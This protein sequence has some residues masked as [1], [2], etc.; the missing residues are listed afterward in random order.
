MARQEANNTFQ[1]GMIKDLN[2]INT[3]N[4]TLTDCLNGTLITYNG[5]EFVLQNDLGNFELENCKLP[6]NFIPVG[7]KSY[8]DILYIVSYNPI[9][10]ETEIGS[11]PAP[12]E[13]FDSS[14]NS[15]EIKPVSYFTDKDGDAKPNDKLYPGKLYSKL[16]NRPLSLF[17]GGEDIENYKLNP[18]DQYILNT[19]D[20]EQPDF[21]YQTLDWYILDD[22]RKT[23]D[24]DD[25]LI[26]ENSQDD[27]TI[28]WDIP[29]W[30]A[31]KYK[32]C[33]PDRFNVNVRTLDIPEFAILNKQQ[34]VTLKLSTQLLISDL[35]FQ[36]I[37]NQN[38]NENVFKHLKIRVI[39][40]INTGVTVKVK[41]NET[42]EVEITNN[43]LDVNC[44]KYN[45]QDDIITAFNNIEIKFI[46]PAITDTSTFSFGEINVLL[47]PIIDQNEEDIHNS[48]NDLILIY[49]QFK[50]NLIFNT[51]NLSTP[52]EIKIAETVY[53]WSC[54]KDSCTI[55][56]DIDGPFVNSSKYYA[57]YEIE[58]LYPR[59]YLIPSEYYLETIPGNPKLT[60][61][62]NNLVLFGQN[63]INVQWDKE[64]TDSAFIKEGGL[65]KFSIIIYN[66]LDDE[67]IIRKSLLLIPSEVFNDWFSTQDSYLKTIT[68]TEWLNK[69]I[70]YT[71]VENSI[72][73]ITLSGL[74]WSSV[75]YKWSNDENWTDLTYDLE[76]KIFYKTGDINKTSI[77]IESIIRE[78]YNI[79]SK[80]WTP[81][82]SPIPIT[83]KLYF[84][85]S[86]LDSSVN[87][88]GSIKIQTPLQGYLWTVDDDVTLQLTTNDKSV[89]ITNAESETP[90][91][92][93]SNLGFIEIDFTSTQ[94]FLKLASKPAQPFAPIPYDAD[95]PT[96]GAF[97]VV[98]LYGEYD[99]SKGDDRWYFEA[100]NDTAYNPNTSSKTFEDDEYSPEEIIIDKKEML[101]YR[102]LSEDLYSVFDD[103]NWNV[104]ICRLF[105]QGKQSGD[106]Q[107]NNGCMV[108][109]NWNDPEY[110]AQELLTRASGNDDYL[111]HKIRWGLL[112]K[113]SVFHKMVFVDVCSNDY[114]YKFKDSEW[115][116]NPIMGI[117]KVL[118]RLFT[119][120]ALSPLANIWYNQGS[121]N[122]QNGNTE[123]YI[124][125]NANVKYTINK[126]SYYDLPWIGQND[127][128]VVKENIEFGNLLDSWTNINNLKTF[129]NQK[130]NITFTINSIDEL[131]IKQ[132]VLELLN[133]FNGASANQY[134]Y[135][136]LVST[137]TPYY[138][139]DVVSDT[140]TFPKFKLSIRGDNIVNKWSEID[141]NKYENWLNHITVNGSN[142][143]RY[144]ISPTANS[145]SATVSKY[146]DAFTS[147]CSSGPLPIVFYDKPI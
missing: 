97:P 135:S 64:N 40:T 1:S 90:I 78:K 42:E 123:S 13:I 146:N 3:P 80:D 58:K 14:R 5:N 139:E 31:A 129:K 104:A 132:K 23:Y 130:T 57:K 75:S 45:Y 63:T 122:T 65:Y 68:S 87:K 27:I 89:E 52:N 138:I 83:E 19:I 77:T 41:A 46:Y 70:E 95:D 71:S 99:P 21:I 8:G 61:K 81:Y 103:K 111:P 105:A 25:S 33:V 114:L 74:D 79:N 86:F 60:S 30:L 10:K 115:T 121:T 116:T 34:T 82:I 134:Y 9:T 91:L 147:Q 47:V 112:F 94:D 72:Q 100:S 124:F 102:N 54:D 56:F 101:Q 43:Y 84:R 24:L 51:N 12:Q 55:T 59:L 92:D 141:S 133:S 48:S 44:I 69:Y 127:I 110:A 145:V 38:L 144:N 26:V 16:D 119:V 93:T 4:T 36:R 85:P 22:D 35:K 62:I 73:N 128:Q 108:M 98:T 29:G 7:I 125:N 32:L 120:T 131:G 20:Q 53:K 66:S 117:L 67:E 76:N 18:G 118:Q 39:P 88:E 143:V 96:N 11:Y 17:I 142:D 107:G 113:S 106:I 6:I 50:T 15:N 2:P 136:K 37:L 109:Y 49:D 140:W 126:L 137:D 28:A